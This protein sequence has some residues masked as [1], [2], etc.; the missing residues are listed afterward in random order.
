MANTPGRAWRAWIFGNRRVGDAAHDLDGRVLAIALVSAAP[1]AASASCLESRVPDRAIGQAPGLSGPRA[2]DALCADC[3]VI[4]PEG[5]G[6]VG[7]V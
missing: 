1:R 5:A 4:D 6:F 7:L 2:T 3:Y